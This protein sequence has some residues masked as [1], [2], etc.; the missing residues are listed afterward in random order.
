MRRKAKSLR[1]TSPVNSVGD[2]VT[3]VEQFANQLAQDGFYGLQD[4]SLILAETVREL[5]AENESEAGVDLSTLV[6]EWADLIDTFKSNPLKAAKEMNAYLRRPEL[7]IP[8]EDDEFNMLELQLYNDANKAMGEVDRLDN[9]IAI[10]KPRQLSLD[11]HTDIIGQLADEAAAGGLYGLQDSSLLLVES[12]RGLSTEDAAADPSFLDMLSG[13]PKLIADYRQEPMAGTQA[14]IYFLRHP[15]LNIPMG[16]DEFTML[17]EQLIAEASVTESFDTLVVDDSAETLAFSV[18][19]NNT[20]DDMFSEP[21][22][23][24]AKELVELLL[25]QSLQVRSCLQSIAIGDQD[26]ILNGLQETADELER[27]ANISKTAG[28]EGL[29]LVCEHIDA[30]IQQFQGQVDAF[31]AER[32]TLMLEW[33]EQ[34]QEYLPSFNE[35]NAGQLIV[36]GLTDEQWA[37]PLSFDQMAAILLQIRNESAEVGHQTEAARVETASD[38][39]VSLALPD[40][41]NQELLDLLLQELP[42]HTREFSE[43]VQRMQSGGSQQDVEVA[44][45]AA[46]T[47]KG[48]ANTVGIKGIAVLTHQLE[49]ILIACAK[50]QKLPSRSLANALVNASDCLEAMSEAISGYGS[51]PNDARAVLQEIL[52]WANRIDKEGLPDSDAEETL[53]QVRATAPD[54][55]GA[56][57]KPTSQQAAAVRVN[58]EQIENLFRLS[59]ESIIL[60]SQANENL[61]RVKNQLKAMEQQFSLLQQLSAELEQLIDLKDLTGR[62]FVVG[63]DFDALEMDQYNE[64]HT[65]SRRMAEAAIDAREISLDVNKELDKMHEVLEDQQT[66]VVEAQEVVMQTRLVSVS[67]IAPRLHRSLRQTCRMT[68]KQGELTLVGENIMIDGDTLNAIVDPLMH[69]LRNAVDHGIE[70]SDERLAQREIQ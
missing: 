26:S 14:I 7:K 5:Q 66:M 46:H 6:V 25:M 58:A 61:R 17:Q 49:D 29:A 53:P 30:N 50:E 13:W 32:L 38:E 65:A 68:G 36:A 18:T 40:D 3:F 45:R 23:S 9:G 4:C 52:D 33:L 63:S 48:S 16:E 8:M 1:L 27:F 43:A 56:I 69:I 44:Q 37:M 12:L 35:S 67:T 62:S 10:S 24:V 22:S 21:I 42:V 28:F 54:A 39:D 20:D 34:V 41:V 70:T 59:G 19:G 2:P 60:N 15:V 31:N 57:E 64:L 51:A 55:E 11:E 47:L